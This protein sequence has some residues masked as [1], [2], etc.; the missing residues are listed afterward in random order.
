MYDYAAII[1][2]L[3]RMERQLVEVQA[4]LDMA[5][6]MVREMAGPGLWDDEQEAQYRMRHS[7]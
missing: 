7:N 1:K 5:R 4:N 3:D 6:E 2:V